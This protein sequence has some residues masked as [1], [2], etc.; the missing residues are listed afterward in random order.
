MAEFKYQPIFE[1]GD[2]TTEYRS[3][4]KE[5][6][7]EIELDGRKI[8]KVDPEVLRKLTAEAIHDISHLFRP[9]H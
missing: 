3:L 4:G 5:G 6:V 1:L 7:A 8:L 9:S 2:D